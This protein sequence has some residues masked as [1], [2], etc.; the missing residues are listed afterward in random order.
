[1][2][3]SHDPDMEP[4]DQSVFSDFKGRSDRPTPGFTYIILHQPTN[5]ALSIIKGY[6]ALQ[7][8]CEPI[9]GVSHPRLLEGK[10]HWH[11]ECVESNGWLSFRNAA[12]GKFLGH[13]GDE[14]EEESPNWG[15]YRCSS[16][17]PG[18]SEKFSFGRLP[19]DMMISE[20]EVDGPVQVKEDEHGEG[21]KR[22]AVEVNSEEIVDVVGDGESNE[23]PQPQPQPQVQAS[24]LFS[25]LAR[26]QRWTPRYPHQV[27]RCSACGGDFWKLVKVQVKPESLAEG[28]QLQMVW[29][30]NEDA[31]TVWRFVKV[32]PLLEAPVE[33][34]LTYEVEEV[35]RA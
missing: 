33:D 11:W 27:A 28:L 13:D 5:R 2:T 23:E 30:A 8:A 34:E 20:R 18:L 6:P 31:G 12:T 15:N 29:D 25:L 9:T 14:N 26:S 21:N 24:E 22:G 32:V 4:Q 3:N 35:F 16:T 17:K 7:R 19:L 10:T 1:M